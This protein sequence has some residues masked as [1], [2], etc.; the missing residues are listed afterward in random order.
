MMN[1]NKPH[2]TGRIEGTPLAMNW[3]SIPVATASYLRTEWSFM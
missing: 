2:K 3:L 1:T